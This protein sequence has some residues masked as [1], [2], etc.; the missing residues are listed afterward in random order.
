MKTPEWRLLFG[1]FVKIYNLKC[2]LSSRIMPLHEE[3]AFAK[4][5]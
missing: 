2:L 5:W 3:I 4:P 1:G